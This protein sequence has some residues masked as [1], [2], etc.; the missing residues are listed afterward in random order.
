MFKVWKVRTR[1]GGIFLR[2][3]E[4]GIGDRLPSSVTVSTDVVLF[5]GWRSLVNAAC[6]LT[7]PLR[8]P[9]K[10]A[11]EWLRRPA[12]QTT[13]GSSEVGAALVC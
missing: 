5:Q 8:G 12:A 1:V 3:F 13:V 10:Q 2:D 7:T 9:L 11:D 4:F 6:L